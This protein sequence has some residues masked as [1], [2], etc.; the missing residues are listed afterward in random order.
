MSFC[1]LWYHYHH[2]C[3][4]LSWPHH[5]HASTAPEVPIDLRQDCSWCVDFALAHAWSQPWWVEYASQSTH[6]LRQRCWKVVMPILD[7]LLE[8][9]TT[10]APHHANVEC[11]NLVYEV[12]YEMALGKLESN[13]APTMLATVYDCYSRHYNFCCYHYYYYY[14]YYCDHR[15][16]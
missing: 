4:I 12:H 9:H 6:T 16:E 8:T 14:Y 11:R 10:M 7:H 1:H 15:V 2:H 13:C 3:V 5:A